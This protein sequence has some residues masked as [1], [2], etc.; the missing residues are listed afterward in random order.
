MFT[1]AKLEK[2]GGKVQGASEIEDA[3]IGR[4][5]RMKQGLLPGIFKRIMLVRFRRDKLMEMT[6][7]FTIPNIERITTSPAYSK[8]AEYTEGKRAPWDGTNDGLVVRDGLKSTLY[9]VYRDGLTIYVSTK[10]LLLESI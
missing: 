3:V 6:I 8:F 7:D 4:D 5:F 2:K 1:L 10:G 9:D